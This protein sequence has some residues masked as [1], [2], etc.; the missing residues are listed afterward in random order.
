MPANVPLVI[1]LNRDRTTVVARS[2]APLFLSMMDGS[3]FMRKEEKAF[4]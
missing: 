1:Q 4:N 2:H 3:R